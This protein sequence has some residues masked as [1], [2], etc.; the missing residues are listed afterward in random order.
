MAHPRQVV[1][2]LLGLPDTDVTAVGTNGVSAF[3][4]AC[5]RGHVDIVTQLTA[6]LEV[7]VAG[8]RWQGTTAFFMACF[9][10]HVKVCAWRAVA[11]RIASHRIAL[12][13]TSH[14]PCLR[15]C[16]A[17]AMGGGRWSSTWRPCPRWT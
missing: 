10:N 5:L 3:L 6:R 11:H 9:H 8:A 7:D 4:I 17:A 16:G 12:H 1:A 14:R 13:H 15:A 2:F